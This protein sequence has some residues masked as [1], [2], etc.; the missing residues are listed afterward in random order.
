[1]E[2]TT[3]VKKLKHFDI[4]I[5]SESQKLPIGLQ[6]FEVAHYKGDKY[7]FICG[8]TDGLHT[9]KH[10][11]QNFPEA[12]QN[13]DIYLY[14]Y[15]KNKVWK[16]RMGGHNK[17]ITPKMQKI[18]DLISVTSAQSYQIGNKFYIMGG[19]GFDTEKNTFN[20]K[21]NL[22]IVNIKKLVKWIKCKC[23]KLESALTFI[24]DDIFKITGG[25]LWKIR[26]GPFLLIFGQDYEGPY[27]EGG[28]QT[29]SFHV[30]IIKI[31]KCGRHKYIIKHKLSRENPLYRRRDFNISPFILDCK[32]SIV[33][34]SGVF[35]LDNGIWTTPINIDKCGNIFDQESTLPLKLMTRDVCSLRKFRQGFNAYE[36]A[37]TSLYSK[38]EKITYIILFGGLTFLT[39]DDGKVIQNPNIP[40]TN[41]VSVISI[42]N[43]GIIKPYFSCK[44]IPGKGDLKYG[45]NA[46][47]IPNPKIPS[48]HGM[49]DLDYI[50]KCDMEIGKIIGGIVSEGAEPKSSEDTF[51]SR[52]IFKVK[53]KNVCL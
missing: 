40:F 35:T 46:A 37:I 45:S 17:V 41:I 44:G 8:R 42:D 43:C 31:R 22:T 32:P 21:P 50:R 6:D 16:R 33:Q 19:Y 5:K 30:R 52:K 15:S 11:D 38:K 28:V 3:P 27:G 26:K 39:L 47:F 25:K 23:D 2:T 4:D 10:S 13:K 9:F 20:T 12:S 48:C 18:I 1:M 14:D 36:S 24:E 34:L 29:Y 7:I 51:A 49:L 53:L